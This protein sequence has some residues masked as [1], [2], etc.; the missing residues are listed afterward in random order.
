MEPIT[1]HGTKSENYNKRTYLRYTCLICVFLDVALHNLPDETTCY[2]ALTRCDVRQRQ[3]IRFQSKPCDMHFIRVP[4]D[5]K[6]H[7]KF[8]VLRLKHV[9]IYPSESSA[10]IITHTYLHL[11]RTFINVVER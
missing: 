9:V 4:T 10:G 5:W 3:C 7:A 8:T 1:C 11:L 2:G 6:V